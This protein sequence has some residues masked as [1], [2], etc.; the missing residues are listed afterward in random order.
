MFIKYAERLKQINYLIKQ[1]AT[2]CPK[3]FAKRLGI[4]ER[5]W[6]KLRDSLIH[7][8]GLPIAYC[9]VKKTYYYTEDGSFE[10]GFRKIADETKTKIS[11]GNIYSFIYYPLHYG[12]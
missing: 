1:K 4:T 3:E 12:S 8:L 11:A 6:Y 7:D 10:I 9:H 5:A 2:G